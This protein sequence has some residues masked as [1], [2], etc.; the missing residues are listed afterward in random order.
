MKL[1][2]VGAGGREHA[3]AWKLAREPAVTRVICAPG[4]AGIARV[5]RT[6]ADRR[7]RSRRRCSRSPT[8]SASI[9]TVVGPE[10]PLDRGIV[11][12]LSRRGPPHLRS[13]ARR[14]AAR[15][16][17]GRSRRR[18]W[19]ATAFPPRATASATRRPRRRRSL[20][21]GELGF[22]GRDQG[23]RPGGRQ[24]RGRRAPTAT[25]A[26]AA[27][28]R[29]D[30]RAAVRRRRRPRRA[31]GVPRAARRCRSSRCATAAAPCRSARRRITSACSTATAGRTP[32]AWGR[33]R[34]AR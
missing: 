30:G 1:L 2:V 19:R 24:G 25:T 29:R 6:A 5:A 21:R 4:N 23:G 12:L 18:S 7:R 33:S 31:R 15:V 32:A 11:D 10:L 34:R 3:L 20:A 22:P 26:D 28:A 17:Q 16:Q 27:I 13:V 9:S 8:A 14:R